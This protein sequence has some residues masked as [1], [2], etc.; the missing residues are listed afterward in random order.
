MYKR[1]CFRFLFRIGK[2]YS[3][4]DTVKL[5][6]GVGLSLP[7]CF[8]FL[9]GIGFTVNV[10]FLDGDICTIPCNHNTDMIMSN[11]REDSTC[12]WRV[13]LFKFIRMCCD[14]LIHTLIAVSGKSRTVSIE[15]IKSSPGKPGALAI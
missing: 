11:T 4:I 8:S 1:S 6:Q 13:G 7:V 9:K 15:L 10:S 12:L 14:K 2:H 5:R 3:F